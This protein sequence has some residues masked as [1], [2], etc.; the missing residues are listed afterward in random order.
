MAK[1]FTDET[2]E[3][4]M[5]RIARHAAPETPE[6]EQTQRFVPDFTPSRPSRPAVPLRET[7]T[8]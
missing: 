6:M 8:R 1:H 5:P 2:A 4:V 3:F 7:R